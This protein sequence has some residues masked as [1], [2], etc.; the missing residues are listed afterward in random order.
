MQQPVHTLSSLFAQLGEPN[1][2][3]SIARFIE[4]HDHCRM[5]S[6]FTRRLSGRLRRRVFCASRCSTMQTGL[7]SPT[8]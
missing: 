5:T 7:L 2:E 4:T 8:N 3:A 6:D 1:D